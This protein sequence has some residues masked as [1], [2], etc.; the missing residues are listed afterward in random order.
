MAN[1]YIRPE[2]DFGWDQAEKKISGGVVLKRST[3][4][5]KSNRK[6]YWLLI[7]LI[8]IIILFYLIR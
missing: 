4:S 5:F 7:G 8:A 6:V 3:N 2:K 1:K